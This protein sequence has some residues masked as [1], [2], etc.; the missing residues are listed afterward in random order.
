MNGR[1]IGALNRDRIEKCPA[2]R[3]RIR[4]LCAAV[5]LASKSLLP[6][7]GGSP[8]WLSINCFSLDLITG[9]THAVLN[10]SAC[11]YILFMSRC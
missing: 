8:A 3:G 6:P 7:S 4:R 1:N 5:D 9:Q 2:D 10:L 11:R